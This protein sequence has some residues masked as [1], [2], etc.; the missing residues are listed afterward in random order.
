MEALALERPVITTYVAGI[1]ELVT[2][3]MCGWMVAA[4]SADQ[5]ASAIKEC[6]NT[7]DERIQAM[8]EFGRGRVLKQH[9]LSEECRKLACLFAANEAGAQP[10]SAVRFE[11]QERSAG[12]GIECPAVHPVREKA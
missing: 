9:D 2:E 4:G 3:G 8:G 1:P 6:L 5:L 10:A 7:P 11:W 12:E